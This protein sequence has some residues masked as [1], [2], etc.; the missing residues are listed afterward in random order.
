MK[1]WMF[2]TAVFWL[3]YDMC[4]CPQGEEQTAQHKESISSQ[5]TITDSLL[6]RWYF[7]SSIRPP[8][9]RNGDKHDLTQHGRTTI[10]VTSQQ[11]ISFSL[12]AFFIAPLAG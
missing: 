3:F 5:T 4:V 2:V 11:A 9:L 7:P 1:T 8:P 10:S 12:M 6:Q